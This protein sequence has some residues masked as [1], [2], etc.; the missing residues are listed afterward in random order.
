VVTDLPAEVIGTLQRPRVDAVAGALLGSRCTACG[1]TA[2]P[3]RAVCHR[4]RSAMEISTALARTG[5]LLSYTQ[6]WVERPG[7]TPPYL[8]G[9]V[10][11]DDGTLLFGHVRGL[12][13][14]ARVPLPVSVVVGADGDTP[15]FWFDAGHPTSRSEV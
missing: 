3:S 15:P 7:L 13:D 12:S 2:W 5:R 14:R 9:Q 1:T 10:C 11:L 6:V 8:I 4:C